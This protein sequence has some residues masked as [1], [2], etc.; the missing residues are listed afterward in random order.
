VFNEWATKKFRAEAKIVLQCSKSGSNLRHY[1]LAALALEGAEK[2][3]LDQLIT[4]RV[5][6]GRWR[7]AIEHRP[8]DIK[9]IVDFM[10]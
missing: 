8:G 7:E 3:W 2:A 6:L 5:P 1:E 9:V 10:Q 4:R